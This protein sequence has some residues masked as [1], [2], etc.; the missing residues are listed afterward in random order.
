MKPFT[1]RDA[2]V[3]PSRLPGFTLIELLVVIAIIAIL[4]ALLLPALS[5]AKVKAQSTYCMNNEKQMTLAWLIYADDYNQ[6]FVPNVG[7]GQGAYYSQSDSWCYGNVSALPDET[8]T[9]YLANSLLGP[10][11]KSFGIYKCPAD[12]GVPAGTPRVRSISMNGF[13]NGM[14]GGTVAGFENFLK[15]S[16]LSANGGPSQWFVFLDEKPVS[17][18]DEYFEVRMAQATPVTIVM[19]DWPSQVHGGACGFGFADGHAEIHKWKGPT[20]LSPDAAGGVTFT[21]PSADFNDGFW[22]TSHTTY[23]T[24]SSP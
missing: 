20:M 7:D 13:M 19:N 23:A 17:I 12:P 5:K 24:P 16:D 14:G 3:S 8:N 4:A 2:K 9:T 18:N 6:K 1:N 11:T 10:Y 21:K 22:L 15:A